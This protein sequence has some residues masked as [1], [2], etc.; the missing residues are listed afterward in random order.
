MRTIIIDIPILNTRKHTK[1]KKK[2][3]KK[4][5]EKEKRKK[6]K[7]LGKQN[8]RVFGWLRYRESAFKCYSVFP[9]S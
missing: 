2:K 4:P 1:K 6:K 5:R 8:F 7:K 3:K 9:E